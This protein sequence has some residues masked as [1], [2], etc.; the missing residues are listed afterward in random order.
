MWNK[1]A[2]IGWKV[3]ELLERVSQQSSTLQ[4]TRVEQTGLHVIVRGEKGEAASS[5]G[6]CS[7][8]K[9]A[10]ETDS[11]GWVNETLR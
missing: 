11:N 8:S 6:G 1:L 4:A 10:P 7:S 2:L 9:T 5:M 3:S